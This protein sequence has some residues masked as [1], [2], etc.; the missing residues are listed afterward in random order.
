[1]AKFLEDIK[2]YKNY[3][4]YAAKSALKAEVAGSH[5]GW[6]WWIL[7]PLMFMLVYMFVASVVFGA[8]EQYFPLFVFIGLTTWKFFE[9]S[10]KG[11]VQLVAK[12]KAIVSKVY[13]PKY[14]FLM[15]K[16]LVNGFKM[17]V[18]FAL[19]V[20]MMVFFQVPVSGVILY[21]VP[22]M[23]VLT[24][25]TFGISAILMHFGVFLEDLENIVT[26]FMKLLFYMTGIFYNITKSV[27]YP[28]N[29]I[30]VKCNPIAFII[31]EFR[32][33]MLYNTQPD[34]I[35]LVVWFIIGLVLSA[36]GIRTIYKYEN[37]YVKV[38]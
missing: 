18:S 23:V 2:K 3:T 29:T 14:I 12:Y 31:S 38:S 28:F 25:N 35:M 4:I 15:Q 5:L 1:M 30:L 32:N 9:T 36:I 21:V 20:I 34:I 8:R 19:V 26:I 6:L 27:P 7:D 11:S 16:M 22:L 24:L 17:V 10:V 13:V 37:S 33:V